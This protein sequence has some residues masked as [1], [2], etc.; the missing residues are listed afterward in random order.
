MPNAGA[1]VPRLADQATTSPD[2]LG[3]SPMT[4]AI[5]AK[6]PTL[7]ASAV[8][9]LVVQSL[10]QYE[11]VLAEA[12]RGIG[13][14]TPEALLIVD[15]TRGW[16]RGDVTDAASLWMEVEDAFTYNDAGDVWG[17]SAEAGARLVATLRDFSLLQNLAVLDAAARFLASDPG[18]DGD[19]EALLVAV[20]L[21]PA[22]TPSVA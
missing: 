8:G 18:A 11:A 19:I 2:A 1:L 10:N 3:L 17:V 6:L 16:L 4:Q 7:T 22:T 21:V 12:L 20:G 14:T 15:T 13:F 5:I 9:R